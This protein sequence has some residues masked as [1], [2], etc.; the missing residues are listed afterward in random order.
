MY[1]A[2]FAD[3]RHA[4]L[5]LAEAV[6]KQGL[7][8]PLVVLGLP[9]GGVPVAFAVAQALHAP[10]D[11][12]PVRKIGLP[13]Q[14]EL[15]IGAVAS[16]DV[17]VQQMPAGLEL[18]PARFAALAEAE[19]LELRRRE[20]L[21]RDGRRALDL[22]NKAVVIVDDGLATG[23][24]MLAAVRAARQ[25]GAAMVVAAAPVASDEAVELLRGACDAVVILQIPRFLHAVGAWYVDFSQVEDSEV[26]RLLA[27]AGADDRKSQSCASGS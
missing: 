11:V 14:P 10:L 9:R 7:R 18:D 6:S 21:Y 24:T 15:A 25:A 3:R 22:T 23:A 16:G 13:G 8:Q 1:G 19:R 2:P 4:G 12:L 17:T 26:R 5:E 20:R 27:A